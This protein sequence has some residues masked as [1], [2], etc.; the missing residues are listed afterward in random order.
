MFP[1]TSQHVVFIVKFFIAWM[2]PDVP[3]EVKAKIKREK[4]LT[5]KILHEYE[6]N[7]LRQKL[8]EG[9]TYANMEKEVIASEGRVELAE[10][11]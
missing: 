4:Y 5:Q 10:V 7:K 11:M 2:I 3:S 8:C 6:L 9:R 1:P